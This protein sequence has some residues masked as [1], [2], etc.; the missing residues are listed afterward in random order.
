MQRR[1]TGSLRRSAYQ[2]VRKAWEW[3]GNTGIGMDPVGDELG[4]KGG[5]PAGGVYIA[6][7]GN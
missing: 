6:E 5:G 2:S 7:T 3:T 1:E 4:G